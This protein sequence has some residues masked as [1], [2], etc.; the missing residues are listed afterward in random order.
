MSLSLTNTNVT[1]NASS[2]KTESIQPEKQQTETPRLFR[3]MFA[4]FWNYTE[5]TAKADTTPFNGLL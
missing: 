5:T 4:G 3:K 1:T 2:H